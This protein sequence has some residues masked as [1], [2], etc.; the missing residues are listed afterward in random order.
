MVHEISARELKASL[1]EDKIFLLDVRTPREYEQQKLK[2]SVNI[3]IYELNDNL[4][5][6][7]KSKEIITICSHGERSARAAEFLEEKGYKAK[8]LVGGLSSWNLAFE[9]EHT[10]S[11]DNKKQSHAK[12]G[13]FSFSAKILRDFRGIGNRRISF[14]RKHTK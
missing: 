12:T 14:V 3:P 5:D 11:S 1:N 6:I 8:S 13:I 7:P 2:D 9:S 4:G 10:A